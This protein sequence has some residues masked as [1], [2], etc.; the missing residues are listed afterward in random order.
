MRS[1]ANVSRARI[2]I[3]ALLVATGL[4]SGCAHT[5]EQSGGLIGAGLGAFIGHALGGDSRT[6]RVASATFGGLFGAAIGSEIGRQMDERD[7]LMHQRARYYALRDNRPAR[8]D[9]PETGNEGWVTPGPGYR[10]QG[11]Y[12]REYQ[13]TIIVGGRPVEGYGTACQMP[14]GSWK[15]LG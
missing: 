5:N 2:R 3:I 13:Q 12:C 9:N 15:I 11:R 10:E 8:W 14:D 6:G 7:R 1:I 4:V